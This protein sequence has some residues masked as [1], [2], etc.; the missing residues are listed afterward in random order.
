ML[1]TCLAVKS[2]RKLNGAVILEITV[3]MFN[4]LL[5]TVSPITLKKIHWMK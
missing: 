3:T 5:F 4:T 1:H 2:R